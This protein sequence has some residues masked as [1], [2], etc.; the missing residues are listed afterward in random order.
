MRSTG[1]A[2]G[3]GVVSGGN[4]GNSDQDALWVFG[5]N[6]W[7]DL[8]RKRMLGMGRLE[9]EINNSALVLSSLRCLY[10]FKWRNPVGTGF[11]TG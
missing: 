9:R 10:A 6:I 2:N 4:E 8:L 3:L 7:Y 5:L 1:L 11:L